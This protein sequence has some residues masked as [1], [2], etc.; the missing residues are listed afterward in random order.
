MLS[1]VIN[2][3]RAIH[4]NIQIMRAFVRLRQLISRHKDLQHKI[5]A[6]ERK[7]QEKFDIHD[8]QFKMVF[9]AFEEIKKMLDPPPEK[10]KK[11]IGFH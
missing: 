10:K 3:P 4:V 9:D 6:L 1:S 2:S 8:T 5:E 7:M 11:H